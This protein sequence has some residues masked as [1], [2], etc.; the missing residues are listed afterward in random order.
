MDIWKFSNI[1][2]VH[3]GFKNPNYLHGEMRVRLKNSHCGIRQ[4]VLHCIIHPLPTRT[5]TAVPHRAE[6]MTWNSCNSQTASLR[7]SLPLSIAS[8]TCAQFDDWSHV[9][10]MGLV[11][12]VLTREV[13]FLFIYASLNHH[14]SPPSLVWELIFRCFW[15]R[16]TGRRRNYYILVK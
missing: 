4:W 16:R 1:S 13:H 7:D 3:L 15:D 14:W 6:K 5:S 2:R 12:T 10:G 11:V 8:S 9:F